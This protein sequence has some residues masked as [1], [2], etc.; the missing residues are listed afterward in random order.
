M[1]LMR[2]S[3]KDARACLRLEA[4]SR[5]TIAPLVLLVASC[6][7]R[8]GPPPGESNG[9]PAPS[10]QDLGAIT[11][12]APAALVRRARVGVPALDDFAFPPAAD[13]YAVD[14]AWVVLGVDVAADGKA[15]SVDVLRDP[16]YGFGDAARAWA[17]TAKYVPALNADG[18]AVSQRI[19]VRVH[20][21]RDLVGGP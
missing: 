3:R 4:S 2:T 20:F 15:R 12:N 18:V 10:G 11:P 7:W 13:A 6:V 14:E 8:Q 19:M 16:G 1:G 5:A 21:K 9:V 17:L